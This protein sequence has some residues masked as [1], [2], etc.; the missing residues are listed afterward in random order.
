MRIASQ[1]MNRRNLDIPLS[2]KE[3]FEIGELLASIPEE[4][5]PMEADHMDGYLCA[6]Q[7]MPQEI[8]PS[9]WMPF[10]FD[11]EGR[12]DACLPD[13]KQQEYLEDLVFRRFRSIGK[14][15]SR[16]QFIDPIIYDAEDDDGRP[17]KGYDAIVALSPFAQGFL[18]A[19]EKWSMLKKVED[20]MVQSA[21]IGI[22]RHLPDDLIGDLAQV[23]SDLEL[24]SP[25]E[26]LDQAIN[27]VALSV[28]EI[29]SVTR[30]FPLPKGY[31]K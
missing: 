9:E 16:G 13:P 17:L 11:R 29:A 28:S 22:Y 10:V 1:M 12:E 24:E 27:D 7:C 31:S 30:K 15:L 20:E 26:N 25:L 21:L 2:D 5:E 6:I 8:H 18:E 19:N 3:F 14:T 23:K 4:F